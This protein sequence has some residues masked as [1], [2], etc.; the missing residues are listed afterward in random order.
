MTA[1]LTTA[2]TSRREPVSFLAGPFAPRTWRE[3]GYVQA[4]LAVMPVAF[5]YPLLVVAL[6]AGLAV[7]VVG[8][9]V[10]GWLVRGGR[11]FGSLYRTMSRAM[12]RTEV[13]PPAPYRPR[14]GFWRRL[15]SLLGDVPGWRALAFGLLTLPLAVVTFVVSW[16]FLAIA[17]AGVTHWFWSRWLPLQQASDG[18]WHRGASFGD[19]FFIDT[20][21]RQAGLVLVGVLFA[22]LWPPVTRGLVHVLRL[23]TV[24]LLGPTAASARV[25]QLEHSRG[26]AVLDGDAR[27]R[28]IERDLHDGTQARLV[29][30]AMQ[31]GEVREQL[32]AGGRPDEALALVDAAH[33]QTKEAMAELREIAR[34]IHPPALD[35]GLAVAL[36]TLAARTQL[37]VTVDV[38]LPVA[39]SP[40]IETIAYFCVAELLTNVVK[41]AHAEGA[42]VLVDTAGDGPGTEPGTLRVRV[43]DD[44]RGGAGV[45]GPGTGL[46]GLAERVGTVD[47][48]LQVNSPVGGPTIVTVWLPLETTR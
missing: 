42:Y 9:Y 29:S 33:D 41:H 10:P 27:L 23:L 15:G 38:D 45:D 6:V 48:H 34:G 3:F 17:L 28:R 11:A 32:A 40:E 47:G 43:R 46:R 8:L 31:L 20:P 16:V 21:V 12:L 1:V 5:A 18:T 14:R 22:L 39:P 37:P 35:S 2:P 25:Q 30:V 36:E 24:N 4:F 13:R 7:T 26:Q 19:D 44:G